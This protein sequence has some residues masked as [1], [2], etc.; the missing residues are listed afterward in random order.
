MGHLD[1]SIDDAYREQIGDDRLSAVAEAA[2]K[3]LFGGADH[4]RTPR[5]NEAGEIVSFKWEMTAEEEAEAARAAAATEA[6]RG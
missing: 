4:A 2:H 6:A 5:S 1:G 3:W